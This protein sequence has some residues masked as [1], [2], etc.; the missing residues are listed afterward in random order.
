MHRFYVRRWSCGWSAPPFF[1]GLLVALAVY[2]TF[3]ACDPG[4]QANGDGDWFD[5]I[6]AADPCF[7]GG[8]GLERRLLQ[9]TQARSAGDP[10][11]RA[12]LDRVA[13]DP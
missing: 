5:T 6:V 8:R 9:C 13:R 10:L 3:G 7:G 12:V 4:E 2:A 11:A 1:N